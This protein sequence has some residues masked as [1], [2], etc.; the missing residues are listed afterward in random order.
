MSLKTPK[1]FLVVLLSFLTACHGGKGSTPAPSAKAQDSLP[2]PDHS[3]VTVPAPVAVPEIKIKDPIACEI[4]EEEQEP[5]KEEALRPLSFQWHE[6]D[7]FK[8]RL[9]Q[10][11][12]R[13]C[14]PSFGHLIRKIDLYTEGETFTVTKNCQ[15]SLVGEDLF[16]TA[17]HCLPGDIKPGDSCEGTLQVI[18]P[19]IDQNNPMKTLNCDQLVRVSETYEGLSSRDIQ[20][21]W[22]ILKLKEKSPE[23]FLKLNTDNPRGISDNE[24]LFGF[25][26]LEGERTEEVSIVQVKCRAIQD[27]LQL[28]QFNSDQGPLALLKCDRSLNDGSSGMTLFRK[29][30]DQYSPVSTHSHFFGDKEEMSVVSQ[31]ICMGEGER[32][33]FCEFD[34]DKRRDHVNKIYEKSLKKSK[35]EIDEEL[36]SII[37]DESSPIKWKQVNSEN[38]RSLPQKYLSHFNRNIENFEHLGE[39][40]MVY[41]MQNQVPVYPE[42][43]RR[44][45]VPSEGSFKIPVQMIPKMEVAL[46][47][48]ED[49]KIATYYQIT[50]FNGELVLGTDDPEE[51]KN[52]FATPEDRKF[53]IKF[54]SQETSHE[55]P[56][57]TVAVQ[58]GFA[59]RMAIIPLCS[60]WEGYSDGRL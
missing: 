30:G 9:Q 6:L 1:F 22:A 8:D 40:V 52:G 20:P 24:S 19:E 34:P 16:L 48:V 2:P 17:R 58:G 38:W 36:K 7:K 21:D 43:V 13:G 26:L 18:L 51:I 25:L 54:T 14:P 41:Y 47:E 29:D 49:Q 5:L 37:E 4:S 3:P 31:V 10:L 53:F 46:I 11:E 27:S 35:V 28:P 42:C 33:E 60:K 32:P 55:Y 56:R 57:N 50:Y 59:H 23:R 44:R 15:G 39:A 45:F 12:C